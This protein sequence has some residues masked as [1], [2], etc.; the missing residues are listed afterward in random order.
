LNLVQGLGDLIDINGW[1][2]KKALQLFQNS[3]PTLAE[4]IKSPIIYMEN[5]N[6]KKEI[7]ELEKNNF[8]P[9]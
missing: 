3:N 6:F 7:L 9:K 4:W 8:S 5:S 1:D 2:I